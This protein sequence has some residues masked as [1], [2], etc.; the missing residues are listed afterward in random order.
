MRRQPFSRAGSRSTL[1]TAQETCPALA[2]HRP[3]RHVARWNTQALSSATIGKNREERGLV[4]AHREDRFAGQA[5]APRCVRARDRART[6]I[7]GWPSTSFGRQAAITRLGLF[8]TKNVRLPFFVPVSRH[9]L[10]SAAT[11]RRFLSC[12][13]NP[14]Q[15]ARWPAGSAGQKKAVTSHRTPKPP[16]RADR[17]HPAPPSLRH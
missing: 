15:L 16:A 17:S 7:A 4:N 8:A 13:G 5:A 11:R 2:D 1:H 6:R 3:P 10:W 12:S 14:S 9:A